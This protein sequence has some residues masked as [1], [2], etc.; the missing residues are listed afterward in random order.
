MG[1]P[2]LL[3]HQFDA[4]PASEVAKQFGEKFAAALADLA[5]GQWQGPIESG[6]GVHLVFVAERTDGRLPA[7][8]DVRDAVRRE[9][10]NLH[11]EKANDQFYAG[12][13]E[14]YT[15]TVEQPQRADGEKKLAAVKSR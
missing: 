2:S 13:L 10:M 5:P 8:E 3:E 7:L 1:D 11:R 6:Y 12:L 9:W 15:V 4:V 14:R